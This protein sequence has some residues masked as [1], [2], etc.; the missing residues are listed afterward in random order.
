MSVFF[1]RSSNIEFGEILNVA[2][3]SCGQGYFRK[4]SSCRRRYFIYG[5]KKMGFQKF[6]KNIQIRVDMTFGTDYMRVF[7]PGWSFSLLLR[8]STKLYSICALE[9][10]TPF[11]LV[12]LTVIF[13]VH[14]NCDICLIIS[15]SIINTTNSKTNISTK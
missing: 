4:R 1:Y 13:S 2:A 9:A 3:S 7:N 15:Y 12:L 14:E 8:F 6:V 5:S 11:V 10:E